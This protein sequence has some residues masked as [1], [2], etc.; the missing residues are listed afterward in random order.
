[1]IS[2]NDCKWCP[3]DL[4][5]AASLLQ[6][7]KQTVCKNATIKIEFWIIRKCWLFRFWGW[8]RLWQPEKQLC[9]GKQ[10]LMLG[11]TRFPPVS[12][13]LVFVLHCLKRYYHPSHSTQLF[14]TSQTAFVEAA[15]GKARTICLINDLWS[16]YERVS[17]SLHHGKWATL[18]TNLPPPLL[19]PTE[20]KVGWPSFHSNQED[21][22]RI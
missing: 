14:H 13:V 3:R 21:S 12:V 7:M 20:L 18:M 5:S 6:L 2:I 9:W 1:M 10:A 15:E 11:R 22:A 17:L 4:F 8:G 19:S 16:F